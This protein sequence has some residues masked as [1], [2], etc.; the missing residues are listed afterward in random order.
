MVRSSSFNYVDIGH[1][2]E[3]DYS[4]CDSILEDDM[5]IERIDTPESF[6][7]SGALALNS[8]I[9]HSN[10]QIVKTTNSLFSDSKPIM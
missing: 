10:Q 2:R 6:P 1:K 3:N 7:R 8:L 4:P 9:S 5:A